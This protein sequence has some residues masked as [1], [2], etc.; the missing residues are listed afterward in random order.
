M[1][2]IGILAFL[3]ATLSLTSP[4]LMIVFS[5]EPYFY[6][7][8]PK[9]LLVLCLLNSLTILGLAR[10]HT[11]GRAWNKVQGPD[12]IYCYYLEIVGVINLIVSSLVITFRS[13]LLFASTIRSAFQSQDSFE[14]SIFGKTFKLSKYHYLKNRKYFQEKSIYMYGNIY[15]LLLCFVYLYHSLFVEDKDSKQKILNGLTEDFPF[16]ALF[17]ENSI[18]VT[19]LAA[20]TLLFELLIFILLKMIKD[21]FQIASETKWNLF[22][23]IFLSLFG[24]SLFYA[25][26]PIAFMPYVYNW[27]ILFTIII[28]QC[29]LVHRPIID[30]FLVRKT[31]RIDDTLKT[32]EGVINNRIA[33]ENFLQFLTREFAAE[34]IYFLKC[35]YEY[36]KFGKASKIETDEI[37]SK[38]IE[39]NSLYQ[40]NLPDIIVRRCNLAIE[41]KSYATAFDEAYLHI[42]ELIELDALPRFWFAAQNSDSY[43]SMMSVE[44]GTYSTNS[45][46]VR[47]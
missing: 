22:I 30:F 4:L 26:I 16:C 19:I 1:D 5:D 27:V 43:Q 8:R 9:Y 46:M 39:I 15:A 35:V 6:H 37:F 34:N 23:T 13:L 28:S 42:K 29:I 14:L 31:K 44:T 24:N 18:S 25:P 47:E 2:F 17:G 12:L 38:F 20:T 41:N 10:P 32:I 7:R 33:F 3:Y 36:K 21:N 40:V 45:N 11:F